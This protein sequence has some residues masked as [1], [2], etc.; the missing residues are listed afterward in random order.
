MSMRDY[1]QKTR[2]LASCI[3]S[4]T[5]YCLT[6]AEPATP[7]EAFTIA[8]REDYVVTSSYARTTFTETHQSG[9]EPMEVDAV[10]ASQRQQWSPSRR[11]QSSLLP[12]P[13]VWTSRGGVPRACSR[14]YLCG[15]FHVRRSN[16]GRATKNRPGPVGA[17]CPNGWNGGP[18]P[19]VADRPPSPPVLHAPFNATTASGDSRLIIVSL[20][21]AG[22]WRPLRAL[23]D[24]GATNNFF[25]ASCRSVV[26]DSVRVRNGPGEVEIKLADG[27]TRRVARREVSLPYQPQIDW[28]ARSVKRPHDFDVGEVFTH[29]VAAPRDWPHV[30][31]VDGASATHILHRASDGPLCTTCAAL[32]TGD[33]DVGRAREEA[34]ERQAS[35]HP[36]SSRMKNVAVEQRLPH[37]IEAVEQWLPH[38]TEA[39]EQRLPHD[40]AAG[41]PQLPPRAT[42][43][44]ED[45]LPHLEEGVSSSSES[46]TSVSGSGSR[47]TKTFRRSRRRLKPRRN[48]ADPSPGQTESVCIIEYADG[49]PSKTRVIEVASP[50]R[51]AKSITHLSGLSWKKFLRDLKAGDIDQVC[52]ITDADS[53]PLEIYSV[54]LDDASSRPK[55]A[56]PK[57]AREERFATQSWETLEESIDHQ[58]LRIMH[59][60]DMWPLPRDQVKAIDEFFEGRRQAGHVRE[61]TS[62]H[63]S[64]TFCATG[65]WRIVH[66]FDKLNAATIPTQTPIPRKDMVLDSMSGSV[67]FSAIDLTDGFYQ[68]LMRESDIPLTAVSTPSGMLWEWLVMPQGLKNA[69]A[70]FNR[71]VSHVLRPLRAEL[72][73]RYLCP[74]RAEDG[75]SAV[76]VHIRHLRQVF[77]V[78]RANNLYA[79]LKK[80]VFCAPEIPVLGCYVS[81]K[82]VRADPEKVSSICS[83]PTPTSPT[84]VRQRLGLANYLHK[85]TKAYAG[86]IQPQS[87]L[88]KKDATWS[89]C[90][91]H[92]AAFD[93][94]KKGL[95]SAP[96]LMLPYDSKPFHVFDNEGHERVVSY[97]S[98]QMKPAE[99]NYP[100]HDKELLAMRYALIK[101][102]LYLLGE[103]AFAVYT[104]HASL[105]TAMKSPHLSQRMA[106]WLSFFAEYNFVVHYKPGKNNILA[107]AL[108]RRPDYDPRVVLG[109]QVIDDEDDGDDHCAVCA[110]SGINLTSV[111][112]EMY[113]RDAIVAAY[114]DDAVY[115]NILA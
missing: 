81:K 83:W 95:A 87:S 29:L 45:E 77:Q 74:Q 12:V 31:V 3:V 28:L 48:F 30:T 93:S 68:I 39:V 92:Q 97:Q 103:Q 88:L 107:D 66:D 54:E 10:E 38:T 27:K 73:R 59:H 20:L 111:S 1:V 51:D 23:L 102:R 98:R 94:V 36:R 2:H 114:T 84:E 55:S 80:C 9:P 47:R 4:M 11:G 70:T 53:V 18:G 100:V 63:S 33:D 96:I 72:L 37:D 79:N 13:D 24:S 22:A 41:D 109:R 108:S 106:R 71:M 32:L 43:A 7:E 17:G 82:G 5:R 46:D 91:E 86:Q 6:R 65:G 16:H 101:F 52:L 49:A 15:A 61:S 115:A 64:P 85:Y 40:D 56:E 14:H 75:F 44:V 90:P 110:A 105:R 58:A 19:P 62:P 8:L 50:P 25:R 26:P 60:L 21:V 76:E 89:W 78:M 99:R 34:R 112:P 35:A 57:S 113:F 67:V 69:P 104:D 42:G